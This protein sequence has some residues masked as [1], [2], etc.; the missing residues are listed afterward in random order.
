MWLSFPH[1]LIYLEGSIL[2][3]KW[4]SGLVGTTLGIEIKIIHAAGWPSA[5]YS[6]PVISCL[7]FLA[8]EKVGYLWEINTY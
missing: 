4:R 3:E 6:V 2:T 8:L 7:P 1:R 5:D